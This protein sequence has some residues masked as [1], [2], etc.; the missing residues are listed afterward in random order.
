MPS[1]SP[2]VA[3]GRQRGRHFSPPIYTKITASRDPSRLIGRIMDLLRNHLQGSET[4][5]CVSG[6]LFP[7]HPEGGKVLS[8]ADNYVAFFFPPCAPP[9]PR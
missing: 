4:W 9:A 7:R 1:Y 3:W 5:A 2:L 8:N 6:A